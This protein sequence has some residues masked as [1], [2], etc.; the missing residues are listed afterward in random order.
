MINDYLYLGTHPTFQEHRIRGS[1][2]FVLTYSIGSKATFECLKGFH[3]TMIE[4]KGSNPI[5]ILVGTQCDIKCAREV[6]NEEGAALAREL[7]CEFLETSAKMGENVEKPFTDLVRMLRSSK[8][9]ADRV[10]PVELRRSRTKSVISR[11]HE[12]LWG[13]GSVGRRL[14]NAC[15]SC[16]R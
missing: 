1:H 14:F 5:F 12:A 15:G 9:D 2:A 4:I 8:G 6:S 13:E 3:R 7:G 10:P 11:V 16:Y